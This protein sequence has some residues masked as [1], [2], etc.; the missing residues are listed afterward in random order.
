LWHDSAT[1]LIRWN[2]Y[3]NRFLGI[4][5]F[6]LLSIAVTYPFLELTSLANSVLSA[7]SL[8]GTINALWPLTVAVSRS[9]LS[10]R[11]VILGLGALGIAT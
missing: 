9:P 5:L 6:A 10:Q 2:Y 1:L 7:A 8:H 3:Y 4:L 11:E